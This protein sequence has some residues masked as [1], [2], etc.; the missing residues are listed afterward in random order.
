VLL[1]AG[2]NLRYRKSTIHAR[3]LTPPTPMPKNPQLHLGCLI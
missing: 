1:P 2:S 3:V